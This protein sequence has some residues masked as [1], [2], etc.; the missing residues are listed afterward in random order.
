M[1]AIK[2]PIEI[3]EE[4]FDKWLTDTND[5][6]ILLSQ[7]MCYAHCIDGKIHCWDYIPPKE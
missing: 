7:G 4:E 2:K 5:N 3:S 6:R 1:T